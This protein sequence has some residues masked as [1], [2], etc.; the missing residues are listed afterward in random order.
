MKKEE[1]TTANG[2]GAAQN[3]A[4]PPAQSKRK[5]A[6]K[7]EVF[8]FEVDTSPAA[9]AFMKAI[10]ITQER[11]FPEKVK[12]AEARRAKEKRA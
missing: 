5:S 11:L 1:S 8:Q 4:E 7:K 2:T 6:K 12:R 9:Q 10:R 3:G